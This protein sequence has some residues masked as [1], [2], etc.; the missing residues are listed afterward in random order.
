[1][2]RNIFISQDKRKLS[3]K[4]RHHH[5]MMQSYWS[6]PVKQDTQIKVV[7]FIQ[8]FDLSPFFGHKSK[9]QKLGIHP[10]QRNMMTSLRCFLLSFLMAFYIVLGLLFAARF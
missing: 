4:K 8:N 10:F 2:R 9:E 5:D 6:M 3:S 7:E 1:M